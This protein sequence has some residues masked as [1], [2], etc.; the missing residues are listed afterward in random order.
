MNFVEDFF[1]KLEAFRAI[2]ARYD[3]VAC[4][5]PPSSVHSDSTDDT[6]AQQGSVGSDRFQIRPKP[7]RVR[8][9]ARSTDG[10]E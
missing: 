8:M 7:A 9:S 3:V 10:R 4:T 1:G 6:P 5:L 2:A